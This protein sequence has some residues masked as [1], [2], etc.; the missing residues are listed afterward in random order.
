MI[1]LGGPRLGFHGGVE[2]HV[3]D[4]ATGLRR[5]GHRVALV[6]GAAEG[7]D[8]GAYA[9][10][11]DA[12]EPVARARSLLSDADVVYLHKLDVAEDEVSAKGRLVVAVHDHDLTCVR[13][14]RYL[15]ISNAPC[16]RAPGL[17][18]AAHGCVVV[19]CPSSS[20]GVALRNPFA[21][22]RS[23]RALAAR[24][25]MVACSGFL[26][27]TLVD[28]G[29]APGRVTVI[30]PVLPDDPAEVTPPP[31]DP[32]VAFVGQIIRG[33]GLDL[34]IEAIARIDGARL[35]VA[36]T[37]NGLAGEQRHAR[38][39]GLGDRVEFLGH[40][41]P[42]AVRGVYDR[43][44]VVAVPSRWPEPFGMIGV[45]AM[46]R[47][48]ITV[49]AR[50]GGIPEWLEDGRTGFAFRPGDVADLAA[51]LRRGLFG[52]DYATMA[53]AG[54]ARATSE[55]SFDRMLDRVEAVL[56]LATAA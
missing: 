17:A 35:L 53:A 12:V 16:E 42:D 40:V 45:E 50:H 1:V 5:R 13:A 41:A 29:I 15:P 2:R 4:L 30:H 52:A 9:R 11:F 21:L 6:H 46:R 28:A 55:L 32:I 37:G 22:A 18:C 8:P 24:A 38:R 25:P 36:G 43:A 47:G 20:S 39:L 54:R 7:R 34:L 27:R 26:R 51:A 31:A 3:L 44:R 56:G 48:R 14:H 19:R 33:K 23:T 10:A 49:G